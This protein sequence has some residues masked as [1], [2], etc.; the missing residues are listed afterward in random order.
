M[1][2]NF[3][4]ARRIIAVGQAAD[5]K[6]V[7]YK[8]NAFGAEHT[9]RHAHHGWRNVNSVR[10]KLRRD[11]IMLHGG[12]DGPGGAVVHRFHTAV[13]MCNVAHARVEGGKGRRVVAGSVRK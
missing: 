2:R 6:R 12:G 8:A 4:T 7:A 5:R 11:I 1:Y 3:H 10:D 9:K 13:E